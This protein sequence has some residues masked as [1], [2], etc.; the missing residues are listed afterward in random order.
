MKDGLAMTA[1]LMHK[2]AA[3]MKAKAERIQRENDRNRVE[4]DTLK[5]EIRNLADALQAAEAVKQQQMGKLRQNDEELHHLSDALRSERNVN[6]E[7][8]NEVVT[9]SAQVQNLSDLSQRRL[10]GFQQAM[11]ASDDAQLRAEELK[12]NALRSREAYQQLRQRFKAEASRNAQLEAQVAD[13]TKSVQ[14]Y[15]QRVADIQSASAEHSKK[16]KAQTVEVG[17][18][19]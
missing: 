19:L 6:G 13:L 18:V 2:Q 4:I 11:S 7:L 5:G 17:L 9:L 12:A 3:A 14:K 16:A 15:T 10:S 1:A 8:R